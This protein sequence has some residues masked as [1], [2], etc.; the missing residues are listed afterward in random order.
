MKSTLAAVAPARVRA[1]LWAPARAGYLTTEGPV[2]ES[3]MYASLADLAEAAAT[4]ERGHNVV[5]LIPPSAAAASP[6]LAALGRRLA[7][8]PAPGLRALLLVTPDAIPEWTAALAA[9][10]PDQ[11][12]VAVGR[13]ARATRQLKGGEVALLVASPAEARALVER[14]AIK[15]DALAAVVLAQPEA[16]GGT[17]ALTVVMHDLAKEA[18]RVVL[19]ALPE[20][21]AEVVERYARKALAV[22]F[23]PAETVPP[24]P[25]GPVRTVAVGWSA[26]G[27]AVAELL[28]LLDPTTA[29][30]WCHDAGTEALVRQA[31]AGR[32]AGVVVTREV[33]EKG[34]LVIAADLPTPAELARLAAAGP[35]VL[36]VPPGAERYVARIAAP[37]SALRLTGAVDTAL[38][39]AARRRAGIAALLEAHMPTEGLLALAPLFERYDPSA[40]AAALY[41]LSKGGSAV[42]PVAAVAPAGAAAPASGP[43]KMYVSVG[44]ADGVTPSDLVAV[45]TKEVKVDR[46]LIGRIELRDTFS[47]VELPAAEVEQIVRSMDGRTVRNKKVRCKVDRE[48]GES[49][50]RSARR[51]RPAPRG[52]R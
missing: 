16:W 24:A 27:G 41:Q 21:S 17:E 35:V 49:R 33:P 22:G 52:R 48:R 29:A 1:Y 4:V 45:L 43:A 26:R 12:V 18:Q 6:L 14:S 44:K 32:A 40:V 2:S 20:G 13:L 34:D 11:R 51:E 46:T 3:V 5:A 28:E 50:E 38:D 31:V 10:I 25:V 15:P 23:L 39:E 8:A 7:A 47:L 42:A 36:L 30:V 19:T 37:R 9:A